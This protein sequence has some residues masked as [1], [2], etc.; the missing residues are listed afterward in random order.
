MT[1]KPETRTAKG[2]IMQSGSAF[3]D[4]IDLV[5]ERVVELAAASFRSGE[6]IITDGSY[7]VV[8]ISPSSV[9]V[10]VAGSA[11]AAGISSGPRYFEVKITEKRDRE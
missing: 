6:T 4:P 8:D 9:L 10:V 11:N 7:D 3:D 5:K 1:K 2:E